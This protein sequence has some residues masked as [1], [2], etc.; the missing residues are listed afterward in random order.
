MKKIIILGV[1]LLIGLA[2]CS[3]QDF[4]LNKNKI[5]VIG[6]EEAKGQ[7]SS[8]INGYLVGQQNQ[9]TLG[10][11][12][13]QSG[14][15]AIPVNLVDGKKVTAY[16]T[17]DGKYFFTEGLEVEKVKQ[18][19]DKKPEAAA[20]AGQLQMETL[21]E[22]AGEALTKTGDVISV[23]YKGTLA[24]NTVFDSSYDRGEPITITLGQ[25]SVIAGWE[26]GLLNMKVGEKRR[27]IIPPGLA[28]G[29]E[30][31][32]PTIPPNSTLIFEVELVSINN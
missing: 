14:V 21:T 17:K 25:N 23:N 15:Y 29:A 22:G 9:V 31:K 16:M 2:G 6:L 5:K 27:L 3:L 30:G 7:A 10:E 32:G 20:P 8:F 1:V 11:I 13:D 26:Q 4:S 24:D 28:Y 12:T 18:E 19:A